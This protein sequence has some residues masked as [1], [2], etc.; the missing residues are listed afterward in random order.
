MILKEV[1]RELNLSEAS[2]HRSNDDH[3]FYHPVEVIALIENEYYGEVPKE[4]DWLD[5]FHGTVEHQRC[6]QSLQVSLW[7]RLQDA[8][9]ETADPGAWK[10]AF[11]IGEHSAV[12]AVLLTML[13]NLKYLEL[14]DAALTY[15]EWL[16]PVWKRAR[17]N[18]EVLGKLE[19]VGVFHDDSEYAE[20]PELLNYLCLVPSLK[21]FK[22]WMFGDFDCKAPERVEGCTS[23]LEFVEMGYCCNGPEAMQTLLKP[24]VKLKRLDLMNYDHEWIHSGVETLKEYREKIQQ[25]CGPM[26]EERGMKWKVGVFNNGFEACCGASFSGEHGMMIRSAELAHELDQMD[27]KRPVKTRMTEQR[28]PLFAIDQGTVTTIVNYVGVA[29]HTTG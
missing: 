24:M 19:S 20:H 3:F 28:A 5:D 10:D 16:D 29:P 6:L 26:W 21:R 27:D 14:E 12:F 8:G 13:S 23:N 9:V 18:L 11:A 22:S 17:S 1:A 2:F 15:C 25:L 7:S 4:D